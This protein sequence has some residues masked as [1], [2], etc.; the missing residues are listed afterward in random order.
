MS[1]ARIPGAILVG[2]KREGKIDIL[3]EKR[4]GNET[5]ISFC[6]TRLLGSPSSIKPWMTN[7]AEETLEMRLTILRVVVTVTTKHGTNT[8][9]DVGKLRAITSHAILHRTRLSSA[10][11]RLRPLPMPF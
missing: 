7:P 3:D 9:M 5:V 6:S 2:T 10:G 8:H 11:Q 4:V 1:G